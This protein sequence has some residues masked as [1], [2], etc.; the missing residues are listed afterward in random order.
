MTYLSSSLFLMIS[1]V[2]RG[3]FVGG[4]DLVATIG[5]LVRLFTS[6]TG[7]GIDPNMY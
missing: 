5:A 3:R 1:V 7:V 4:T 2:T 6:T